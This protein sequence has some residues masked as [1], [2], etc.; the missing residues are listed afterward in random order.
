MPAVA[1]NRRTRDTRRVLLFFIGLTIAAI[2]VQTWWVI[3]QDRQLTIEAEKGNGLVA[4]RLLEEHATQTLQDAER[5]IDA[6]VVAIQA[7]GRDFANDEAAIRAAIAK[8]LQDARYLKALQYVNLNGES[9]ITSLDYPAHRADVSDR[10]YIKFLIGH[11]EFRQAVIGHPLQ[12]RYDSQLVV[13]IARNLYDIDGR[14]IGLISTD[15]RVS[16]LGNV[17]ARVAKDSNATVSLFA[18]EGFVIVRSPFEARYADRDISRSPILQQLRDGPTEGSF[19]DE[20][21]LDDERARLYT[22]R[23]VAGYPV[24]TAYGRDFDS[25]LSAWRNRTEDRI[26]FAG[27]II[28][29]IG[30]L[31]YFL[32]LHIR[33]LHQA[34]TS[35]RRS[36]FKFASIFQR[37]PVPLS[38]VRLD[39][40]QF[41]EVNDAWLTQ[42]GFTREEVIGRTAVELH[43]WANSSDRQPFIDQLIRHH[44]VDQL[45]VKFHH[46]D[47]HIVICL[48]SGRVF[49]T[50]DETMFIFSPLDVTRQREIENEIRDLNQQL[51]ERV[52][53][54]TL[55]LERANRELGEALASLKN[56]QGELIRSEKMAALGSLVAGVAHELNTPIGTSVTVASTLREQTKSMLED[57]RSGNLRRSLFDKFLLNADNGT[58][59]LQR[60]LG[61]ASE[62]VSSFKQVAVDQSSSHSRIFDLQHVLDEVVV[63]L[64]PMYKKTDYTMQLDL[65]R[66][67]RLN[68]YPGAVGQIVTNLVTN[69]LAH[70][71]E[72]RTTGAMRLST[73]ML[74]ADQVE[75]KF[76]DDGVGIPEANQRRVFDP[77]FTTKL[78]HGGSGLGMNIVYNLVT[79]VL[80]GKIELDSKPG[81]GTTFTIVMPRCAPE[82]DRREPVKYLQ[83]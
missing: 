57:V 20:S 63:T 83:A 37:S 35:L 1:P 58:E 50:D 3:A 40:H 29:F 15:I 22:Y 39:N 9:W 26:L 10:K 64:A 79:D 42:L 46:K 80:G 73:R 52:Q 36:E 33:R 7:S 55:N 71:F 32:M 27:A 24:T 56:M 48:L 67:I 60:T 6:L 12:S 44:I 66:G 2:V 11:P 4:V 23:K 47:G 68:S 65:A 45:E 59:I 30:M 38:L 69:A 18:D 34:D 78:G 49:E 62:L 31:T 21:F 81:A 43:I 74:D 28:A 8:S 41:V 16:Y 5:K 14:H 75:I 53:V 25:I 72:G 70:G 13:P 19:E 51:E 54:R 61:R 82:V 17:Y 76:S 77:F